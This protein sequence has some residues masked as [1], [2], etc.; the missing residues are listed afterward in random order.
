[1]ANQKSLVSEMRR[2]L[3]KGPPSRLTIELQRLWTLFGE[4]YNEGMARSPYADQRVS[5]GQVFGYIEDEGLT[6]TALARRAGMSKQAMGELVDRLEMSGYL[7]RI[8]NPR[9]RRAKLILTTDKGERQIETSRRVVSAI[10]AQW[11]RVLGE[12]GL[13]EFRAALRA[14]AEVTINDGA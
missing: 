2:R 11:A 14:L 7:R 9:D 5:S 13:K 6:L 4:R 10:E 3:A 8:A 1:M 12:K